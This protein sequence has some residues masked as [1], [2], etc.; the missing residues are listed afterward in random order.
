VAPLIKEMHIWDAIEIELCQKWRINSPLN[1]TFDPKTIEM[2]VGNNSTNVINNTII[3]KGLRMDLQNN[4]L[5]Y[6]EYFDQ[7]LKLKNANISFDITPEYIGLKSET[8]KLINENFLKKKIDC[9]FIITIRDPIERC[10]SAVK[11]RI[12]KKDIMAHDQIFY[13]RVN[14]SVDP[15]I[16]IEE[17]MIKYVKSEDAFFR[18]NY[19]KII[20]GLKKNFD[21][22]KYLILLYENI[23]NDIYQK[24]IENFLD[25]DLSHIKT[26]TKINYSSDKRL[27]ENL[28]EKIA[29][30][31]TDI[32]RY[33]SEEIPITQNLWQGYKYIKL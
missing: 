6:F 12:K 18:T 30:I 1:L 2:L 27:S 19:K 7:L 11:S 5:K 33:C 21:K 4:L 15:D 10:W 26:N 28:K 23:G 9:K 24:D 16:D 22:S 8:L 17:A 25:I 13:N 32:Y 20:E 31:F 29:P 14:E 3:L